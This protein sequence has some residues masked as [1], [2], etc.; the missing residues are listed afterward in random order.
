MTPR[1]IFRLPR[2]TSPISGSGSPVTSITLSRKRP[3]TRPA[4]PR[5]SQSTSGSPLTILIML[6][7]LIEPRTQ[8]S[9]GRSGTSPQGL[10]VSMGPRAG[11]GLAR[12]TASRK[13]RPGAPVPHAVPTTRSTTP[14][15]AP[16]A[17]PRR[18]RAQ[19]AEDPLDRVLHG[20][21]EAGAELAERRPRVH[22]G[23]RVREE[24]ERGEEAGKASLPVVGLVRRPQEELRLG[25][26]PGHPEE[27]LL[28]GLDHPAGRIAAQVA[29]L[30][31]PESVRGQERNGATAGHSG[32]RSARRPGRSPPGR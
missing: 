8:L 4:G 14:R 16:A 24:I 17:P 23:G 13:R 10:V 26:G 5:R 30:E 32:G 28:R 27:Q 11:V 2:V 19:R 29:G 7:R 6:A 21:D 31:H 1:P 22:Q 3:P 18:H 12:F 20:E 9:Y 25:D 15:A